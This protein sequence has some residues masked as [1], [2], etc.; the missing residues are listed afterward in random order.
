[1][2][3]PASGGRQIWQIVAAAAARVHSHPHGAAGAAVAG[4]Q[5]AAFAVSSRPAVVGGDFNAVA[6]TAN[7]R[8]TTSLYERS[9]C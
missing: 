9:S 3:V 8:P 7:N 1:M 6:A 2:A 5:A 4:V